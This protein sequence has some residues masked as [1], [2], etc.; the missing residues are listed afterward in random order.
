MHT[1]PITKEAKE[2]EQT[3]IQDKLHNNEYNKT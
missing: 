2:K 1:Y 3:I